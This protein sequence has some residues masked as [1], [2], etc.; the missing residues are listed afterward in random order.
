VEV[1]KLFVVLGSPTK[2]C[3]VSKF[4]FLFFAIYFCNINH[5]EMKERKL[6]DFAKKLSKSICASRSANYKQKRSESVF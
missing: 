3:F 2:R 4:Y 1:T 5:Y 6:F